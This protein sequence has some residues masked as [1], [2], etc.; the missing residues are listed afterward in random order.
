MTRSNLRRII[1]S[2]SLMTRRVDTN[3]R[4]QNKDAESRYLQVSRI[5]VCLVMFHLELVDCANGEKIHNNLLMD[6]RP[7]EHIR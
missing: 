3:I 2:T 7:L 1:H 6:L 4:N 5:T